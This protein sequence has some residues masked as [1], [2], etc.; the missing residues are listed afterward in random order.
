MVLRLLGLTQ[1]IQT[2]KS[3][4]LPLIPQRIVRAGHL[5]NRSKELRITGDESDRSHPQNQTHFYTV[6]LQ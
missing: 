2:Q 4:Q 5:F 6:T 3:R 1:Y